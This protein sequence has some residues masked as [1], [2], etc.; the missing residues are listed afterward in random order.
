MRCTGLDFFPDGNR[1][2]VCTWDGDVWLAN[3]LS[4]LDVA[5]AG[6][7]GTLTWQRIA[8]GLFQPLGLKIID[9]RIF[10][11]C[12]DQIVVLND[13]NGDAETDFYECFNNDHQVPQHFHEFAMG[14]QVDAVGNLYL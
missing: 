3:G 6:T 1:L 10:L 11:T 14:L 8:S 7:A 5:V 9:G 4:Q 2:A 12:R 13:L